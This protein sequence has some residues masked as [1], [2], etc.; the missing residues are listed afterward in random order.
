MKGNLII[1]ALCVA[2]L[3]V[4]VTI[5]GAGSVLPLSWGGEKAAQVAGVSGGIMA[6]IYK[7]PSCSCCG[8]YGEYLGEKGYSVAVQK[9]TDMDAIKKRFNVPYELESCH[10]MEVDGYV[11]EG[12]VPEEVVEKLLTERPDIQGIGM[13]GMPSGS[14]GMPGP[15]NEEFVIYEITNKG[16]KGN[17]FMAI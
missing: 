16:E 11:V 6:T 13:A 15:K 9:E 12:H 3:G 10:T 1:G 14:P 2:A 8:I 17:V 4:F 7:S 5:S